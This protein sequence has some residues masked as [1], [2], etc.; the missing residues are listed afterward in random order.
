[1][2][3]IPINY[4]IYIKKI[5]LMSVQLDTFQ[6]KSG[7]LIHSNT[8]KL[9][10][11]MMKFNSSHLLISHKKSNWGIFVLNF[12]DLRDFLGTLFTEDGYLSE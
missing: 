11:T 7:T 9:W 5:M 2:Q 10:M 3:I 8:P 1:M 4:H 12:Y 6:N